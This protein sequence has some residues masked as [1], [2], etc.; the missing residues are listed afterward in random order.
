MLAI[1]QLVMLPAISFMENINSNCIYNSGI[2]NVSVTLEIT[3]SKHITMQY[4][5]PC[6]LSAS[7]GSFQ[8]EPNPV[9]C[10]VN[11]TQ[12]YHHVHTWCYKNKKNLVHVS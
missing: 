12:I 1:I 4:R 9:P 11:K 6:I 5:L 8:P 2:K 3:V 10:N 7:T